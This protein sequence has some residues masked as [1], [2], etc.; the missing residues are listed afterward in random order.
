M[1]CMEVLMTPNHTSAAKHKLWLLVQDA[2]GADQTVAVL[3][4]HQR[5]RDCGIRFSVVL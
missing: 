1:L 3:F 5:G 4:S 2:D